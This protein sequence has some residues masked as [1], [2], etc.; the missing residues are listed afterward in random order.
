MRKTAGWLL[1]LALVIGAG[2]V[3]AAQQSLQLPTVV[4]VGMGYVVVPADRIVVVIGLETSDESAEQA[5]AKSSQI[6]QS[7]REALTAAQY[8]GLSVRVGG[9][10]VWQ[11]RSTAR[12]PVYR[13][14]STLHVTLA[15]EADVGPVIDTAMRLG[16]SSVQSVRFE[17]S[18][19]ESARR[20]ALTLAVQDAMAKA[21]AIARATDM[22]IVTIRRVSDSDD[23]RIFNPSDP[24]L[25]EVNQADQTPYR[26]AVERGEILVQVYVTIEFEVAARS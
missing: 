4:T 10:S 25:M 18:D 17:A 16:A 12:P 20:Q 23:V 7:I 14:T 6:V 22:R 9:V 26:I 19:L 3:A 13:A 2:G 15:N 5:Y 1:C 8:E 21:D 11:Q 24:V